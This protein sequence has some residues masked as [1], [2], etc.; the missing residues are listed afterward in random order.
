VAGGVLPALWGCF[1]FSEEHPSAQST[2]RIVYP[3]RPIRIIHAEASFS[4]F[5]VRD[6][7]R[8]GAGGGEFK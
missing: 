4:G 5:S 7:E 1:A 3:S 8:S 2:V 6:G